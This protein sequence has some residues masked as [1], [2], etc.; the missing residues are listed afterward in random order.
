[1]RRALAIAQT[2][3]AQPQLAKDL[4]STRPS[5]DG[6]VQSEAERIRKASGA[7]YVV[8]MNMD[9]VRWS[10][11]DPKQ[12]GGVV[13]TDPRQALAGHEVMQIDDG[14]LGRSARGKVPLRDAD[15]KIVA[16]CRSASSTTACGRVWSTPFRG[17]S[18]MPAPP[19]Q[20]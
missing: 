4:V 12:I 11:T 6:P 7:E 14:T 8:V 20:G 16:R 15:G 3:A 18:P 13:S 10:H 2:T 9:G 1:M 19:G 17:S 5:V